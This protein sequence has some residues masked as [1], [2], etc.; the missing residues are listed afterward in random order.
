MCSL[1]SL[2]SSN[3]CLDR[4]KKYNIEQVK[5][6]NRNVFALVVRSFQDEYS[7]KT[8]YPYWPQNNAEILTKPANRFK[9]FRP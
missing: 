2:N 6:G 1:S 5:A 9:S 4:C 8:D 7:I 3:S